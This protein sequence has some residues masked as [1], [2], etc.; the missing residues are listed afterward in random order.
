MKRGILVV[1]LAILLLTRCGEA[2]DPALPYARELQDALDA[3]RESAGLVGISAAIIVPGYEP[4]LGTSGES[5][6][7]QPATEDMLFDMGSAGKILVGPLMVKLA[8]EG[9]ISLD[10]PIDTYLPDFPYAD[11]AITIRQ[12]LNHTSG[13]FMMVK[14]PDSPFRKPYAEIDR[15][16]WWT[17]DEIFSE[18]GG[19]PYFAPGEGW[20]Y[21]QSGYQLATLI[22]EAVTSQTM[23]EVIQTHL[24]TPLD[25][26]GMV[27]DFSKPVP[28]QVRVAH[29]WVDTDLDGHYE[30]VHGDSRN[31]I[32]S[33]SRILFYSSA[34]DLAAWGHALFTGKVLSRGSMDEMIDFYRMDDWCG[35]PPLIT[36]Y[37][38]GVQDLDPSLTGGQPAWGHLGSIPGYRALLAHLPQQG[39]TLAVMANTD[40]DNAMAVVDGL[41]EV[42]LQR[43]GVGTSVLQPIDVEPARQPPTGAQVV[44]TFQKESLFCDH[45]AHWTVTAEREDWIDISL[46][47][48]VG[49]NET[50]AEHV[51]EYHDHTVTINGQAIDDLDAYAHDVEHYVVSCPDGSLEI[52]AK[53]LSIYLPPLPEGE[54]EIRWY[55]EITGRFSN[56][57]VD[58]RPGN[59]ME[60][61]AQLTVE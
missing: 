45:N 16:R 33:L 50:V 47:W 51:W 28:E 12:L 60:I 6:P 27:L 25:I 9:L 55:S 3:G 59:F 31:W 34:R 38:L 26:E 10:D 43:L 39:V 11:G 42:L 8:E 22:V 40:S 15:D 29:P 52:W 14:H 37:G 32:A 7:G 20:C 17:I 58:Y 13:L 24:L 48:V 49:A 35:E 21:T 54:Y 46:D 41:L 18:L 4:W 56:G 30:D 5:H 61:V 36:G 2:S 1:T 57:W 44:H 53:G 19:D 23:A